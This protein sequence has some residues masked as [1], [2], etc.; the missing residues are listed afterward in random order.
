MRGRGRGELNLP[1]HYCLQGL[2]QEVEVIATEDDKDRYVA[3]EVPL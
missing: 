2:C 3:G 1:T